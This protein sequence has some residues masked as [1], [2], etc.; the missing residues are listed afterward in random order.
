M[1]LSQ[2]VS[3]SIE[4]GSVAPV[5]LSS[6]AQYTGF[7]NRIINGNML[8]DQ[9]NN[10]VAVTATN[11]AYTLDRWATLTSQ[12]SKYQVTRGTAGGSPL[13]PYYLYAASLSAYSVLTGDYFCIYQ[14]I[15]GTN[16]SDFNWG[17]TAAAAGYTASPITIS[18]LATSNLTGTFGGSVCN[19]GGT[20]S[21]G[22]SYTIPVAST[23]TTISVTIPGDVAGTWA[24]DTTAGVTLR[25]GLG[26][27]ATYTGTA[28]S[29]GSSNII[30]PTGTVSVVGTNGAYLAITAVQLE[31]GSTAT[32]FDVLDFGR[33]LM[34]CQRY[35]NTSGNSNMCVSVAN[36]FASFSFPVEMRTSP[37]VAVTAT[38]GTNT[39]SQPGTRGFYVFSTA[40]N[41]FG[42][43]SS[44]EL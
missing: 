19:A 28:G 10:G 9:R 3:A 43:T 34:L 24:V 17:A 32:S 26:C 31:K 14:P 30:Q 6:L 42:Y 21:Y 18:F 23:W 7:K 4:N 25:F 33:Q 39:V 11:A 37:T 40:T 20:R 22:F 44:A 8:F 35:Y 16:T 12:L 38:A 15:E 27:G 36:S 29:W 5:D 41:N 2:I 1:P 13:S